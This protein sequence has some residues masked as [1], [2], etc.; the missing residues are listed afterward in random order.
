MASVSIEIIPVD[1]PPI[2]R[3][4]HVVVDED[5]PVSFDPLANDTE[6]DG[7]P[8]KLLEFTQPAN[9]TISREP[10]GGLNYLPRTN[11]FGLDSFTYIVADPNGQTNAAE[12]KIIVKPVNDVPVADDQSLT[13]NRNASVNITFSAVDPDDAELT[14][15]VIDGPS[16]GTLWNYPTVATYYPTNGFSGDDRFTYRAND[17]KDD[18]PLATV[19]LTIK[20][21]NNPPQ[22]DDQSVV[23]KVDQSAVIHIAATDLDADPITYEIVQAPR[24]GTLSPSGTNY[25]YRPNPGYLGADDFT[26]RAF[27]GRDYSRT[28]KV[29]ITVTDQNTAPAASDFAI[30]VFVNTPTN[31]VLRASDPESNPLNFHIVTRP[32]NGKLAGKGP[33]VLYSPNAYF[34]GSDRFQFKADD[35][36]LE[37]AAATVTITVEPPN[38]AP[39]SATNQLVFVIKDTTTAVPLSVQ[40]DDGDSLNCPILK[41]PKN[42]RLSGLGTNFVYTPKPGFIG[43]DSSNTSI[44]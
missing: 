31:I 12:V 5:T 44:K 23:T 26:I 17:G 16:H 9:G 29:G 4:D 8:M 15:K 39:K 22:L 3:D 20:D 38:H 24:Q 40:D 42:G 41:G 37:S 35:G 18:G 19:H 11:F 21:V 36:E 25:S 14:Y 43:D 27:D 2:A 13:L 30:K 7:E 33:T 32:S 6:L 34:A 1:D 10:S 28:A